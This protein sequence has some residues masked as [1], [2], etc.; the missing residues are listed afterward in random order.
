MK[1]DTRL[2]D[3]LHILLHMAERDSPVTSETLSQ[4]MRSNPVVVRRIMAGLRKAG[5][6]RSKKGHGGGWSLA[7]DLAHITLAD[8]YIAIGSPSLIKL[9]FRN[10][11]PGCLVE[12]A[13]NGALE[14]SFREAEAQLLRR[15]H[16]ITLKQLS[17][18]FHLRFEDVKSRRKEE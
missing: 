13:V 8:I 4:I 11:A 16:E 7:T 3:I 12:Q 5:Y 10:V 14:S 15:F 17:E 6:V 1:T 18:D 9:G 2:S